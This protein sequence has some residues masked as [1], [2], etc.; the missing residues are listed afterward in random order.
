M[1]D[2]VKEHIQEMLAVDA[3]RPSNSPWAIAVILVH[4]KME[5]Y[6]F[7]LTCGN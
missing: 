1:Y 4:K 6:N 2:K 5:N 7:V 3:I